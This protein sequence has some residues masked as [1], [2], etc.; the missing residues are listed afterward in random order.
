M[1]KELNP[2]LFG[3]AAA[4][5]QRWIE[6]E[7]P[8]PVNIVTQIEARVVEAKNQV[9]ALE[10]QMSHLVSQV[11]EFIKASQVKF[12]RLEQGLQKLEQGLHTVHTEAQNKISHMHHRLGD[13]RA[14]DTKLQEMIDRHQSVLR[15]YELRMSHLQRLMSEKE[16]Q[17][18]QTQA[19]LNEAKMEIARL[20][21]L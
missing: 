11:N 15:S 2:E 8:T 1:Q 14:M 4:G 7:R 19:A 9:T 21:R 18:L 12:N 13:R 3:T 10:G 20:K 17:I 5:S 6:P 16:D